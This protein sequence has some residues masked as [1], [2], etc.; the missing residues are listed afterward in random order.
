MKK[1]TV[2]TTLLVVA[3][4][5]LAACGDGGN[6]TGTEVPTMPG[7][8]GTDLT[9]TPAGGDTGM[10]TETPAGGDTGMETEAPDDLTVTPT[11]G[12]EMDQTATPEAGTGTD[13]TE[14]P[15]VDMTGTPEAGTGTGEEGTGQFVLLSDVLTMPVTGLDGVDVGTVQGAL[16]RR[17]VT[18][19]NA[20]GTDTGMNSEATGTPEAGDTGGEVEP[21][22]TP[23]ADTGA[24]T[25]TG[26]M[27]SED[28]NA[29][30]ISYLLVNLTGQGDT[31]GTGTGDTGAA[32]ADTTQTPEAGGAADATEMPGDTGSDTGGTIPGEGSAVLI[33]WQAFDAAGATGSETTELTLNV[34]AA[35]LASAPA[36]SE[37]M[38][39]TG[40]DETV[41]EYWAGQGLGLPV[42]GP[43][44]ADDLEHVLVRGQIGSLN[45]TDAGGQ[46]LGQVRDF[47]VDAVT[48]ELVYAILSGGETFG[49]SFYA[50]P[51]ASLDWQSGQGQGAGSLGTFSTTFDSSAFDSAPSETAL[52]DFDWSN[53]SEIDMFWEGQ[54]GTGNP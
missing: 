13:L 1:F 3:A 8:I 39:T 40:P 42:T 21:T 36:F 50:V 26:E 49:G 32:G 23:E 53:T 47:V 6:G 30:A 19:M 38:A 10:E 43:D 51:M 18:G 31:S 25:G 15:A 4:L 16:I 46:T 5:L 2:I 20:G 48:G 35:V 52:E 14:T 45:I 29:P 12:D 27:D 33:P 11:G 28:T 9:G 24:G 54:S 41:S 17:P 22:Q 34:D 44:D 7:D 37:D